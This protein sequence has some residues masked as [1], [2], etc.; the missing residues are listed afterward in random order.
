MAVNTSPGCA[1]CPVVPL[2][3]IASIAALSVLDPYPI[4]YLG[5]AVTDVPALNDGS[6]GENF[7]P[8]MIRPSSEVSDVTA[9]LLQRLLLSVVSSLSCWI[10]GLGTGLLLLVRG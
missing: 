7:S 1:L 6:T 8:R 2:Q 10:L 9:R 4:S 3:M 5:L